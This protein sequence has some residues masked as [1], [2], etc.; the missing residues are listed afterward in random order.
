MSVENIRVLV[1]RIRYI[2]AMKIPRIFYRKCIL[3]TSLGISMIR[4]LFE[5]FHQSISAFVCLYIVVD[6]NTN[7][8]SISPSP[9]PRP[10]SLNSSNFAGNKKLPG[11]IIIGARKGGTRALLEMLSLHP[12]VRMAAQEV[13]FFDN[14]TNYARGYSWYLSQMPT[15]EPGQIGVEKSPSYLV[16]PNVASRIRAMDPHIQLLVIVREPVTRLVSDFT[17]ISYN[18]Q[19]KGLSARTFD[20]TII[21]QDGSVNEEYYGVNTGLYNVHLEQWYKFFPRNQVT[22][23]YA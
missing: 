9:P 4:L 1:R 23:R 18:R 21:K 7:I 12:S 2:S 6:N 20:E 13:H 8:S 15:V 5:V 11:C 16:T 3:G 14:Q 10:S 22:H 19:E 17:Q